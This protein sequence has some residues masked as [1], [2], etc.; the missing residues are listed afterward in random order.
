MSFPLAYVIVGHS[1]R[2]AE[3][4]GLWI[5]ALQLHGYTSYL[6]Y[7]TSLRFS[8]LICKMYSFIHIGTCIYYVPGANEGIGHWVKREKSKKKRKG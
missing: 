2:T 3:C 7:L 5:P 4:F 8:F 6:S 1:S